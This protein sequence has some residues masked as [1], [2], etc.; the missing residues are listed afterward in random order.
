M[1]AKVALLLALTA[2][3]AD[4]QALHVVASGGHAHAKVGAVLTATAHGINQ[5][6]DRLALIAADVAARTACGNAGLVYLPAHAHANAQGCVD[7]ARFG[8][9]WIVGAWGACSAPCDG[10]TQT[11]TATCTSKGGNALPP[12]YCPAPQPSTSQPCNT[13][14][15]AA[16]VTCSLGRP[17]GGQTTYSA[18]QYISCFGNGNCGS[19]T[20]QQICKNGITTD[21]SH[22][23][24]ER[25]WAPTPVGSAPNWTSA[26]AAGGATFYLCQ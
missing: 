1:A 2:T 20:G 14:A 10:G 15:C 24:T 6:G 21:C 16:P 4:A 3:T 22:A 5:Q 7:P 19:P 18:G 12:S 25:A 23:M 8:A 17:F 13:H 26:G 11:R 9:G